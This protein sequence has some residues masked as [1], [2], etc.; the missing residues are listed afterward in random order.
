MG[1][2]NIP[3]LR[4]FALKIPLLLSFDA[5]VYSYR[6]PSTPTGIPLLR[7][8]RENILLL[9]PYI[10]QRY[11]FCAPLALIYTLTARLR[12]QSILLLR[13]FGEGRAIRVSLGGERRRVVRISFGVKVRSK[14]ILWDRRRAVRVQ[15]YVSS[16]D[17]HQGYLLVVKARS[18]SIFWRHSGAIRVYCGAK[19][20]Q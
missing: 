16:K 8:R 17:A 7:P 9:F 2:Q 11:P 13:A 10:P 18:K 14:S 1:R 12:H 6:A 5:K 20:T 4:A 19:R 15:L 3:L